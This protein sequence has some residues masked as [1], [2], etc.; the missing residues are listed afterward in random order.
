MKMVPYIIIALLALYVG[1]TLA[2]RIKNQE[3]GA[4]T[5][6]NEPTF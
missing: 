6:K 2:E 3:P 1:Y 4:R 5:K